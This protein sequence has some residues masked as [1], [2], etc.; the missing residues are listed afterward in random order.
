MLIVILVL[1]NIHTYTYK[2]NNWPKTLFL[3]WINGNDDD[4]EDDDDNGVVGC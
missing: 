3:S 2:Y 4:D 1:Y